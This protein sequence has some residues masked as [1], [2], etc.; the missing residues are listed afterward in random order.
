MVLGLKGHN[1][2]A[3]ACFIGYFLRILAKNY[4]SQKIS[5]FNGDTSVGY[6]FGMVEVWLT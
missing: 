4:A 3:D 5:F 6:N 1:I 2:L